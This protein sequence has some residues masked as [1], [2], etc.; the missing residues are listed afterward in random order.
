MFVLR[1]LFR[2]SN[3]K[4]KKQFISLDIIKS[5]F[6][7]KSDNHPSLT[8]LFN[9][10]NSLD[11]RKLN[12]KSHQDSWPPTFVAIE[13][14]LKTTMKV[15]VQK[16]IIILTTLTKPV[17]AVVTASKPKSLLTV[18]KVDDPVEKL[19][20]PRCNC[21]SSGRKFN[22]G[23]LAYLI[24]SVAADIFIFSVNSPKHF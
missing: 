16:L 19:C 24:Q 5:R 7:L 15:S 17:A 9:P 20:N 12:L 3:E 1:K 8:K 13:P 11:C 6:V 10:F 23:V 21:D 18:I 2:E 4:C 14:T 22:L